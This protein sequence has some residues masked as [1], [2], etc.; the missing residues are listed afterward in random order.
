MELRRSKGLC[1]VSPTPSTTA[2]VSHSPI[3]SKIGNKMDQ[4]AS[5]A[6]V[7]PLNISSELSGSGEQEVQLQ[8]PVCDKVSMEVISLDRIYNNAIENNN[9]GIL[10]T[11]RQN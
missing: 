2:R 11:N 3:V 1:V 7:R 10:N 6:Q 4:W 9:S 8:R 5:A